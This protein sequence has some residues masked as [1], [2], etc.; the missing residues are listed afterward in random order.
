MPRLRQPNQ[1]RTNEPHNHKG[2]KHK[3][4]NSSYEAHDHIYLHPAD[5]NA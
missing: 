5:G 4:Q 2:Y 3:T 1:E